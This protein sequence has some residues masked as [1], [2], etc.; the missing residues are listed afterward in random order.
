[1]PWIL[2]LMS[3]NAAYVA[4][5]RAANVFYIA[6]VVLHPLLGLAAVVWVVWK[7][8]RARQRT[9]LALLAPATLLGIYLFFAGAT[10]DHRVVLWSHVA[11]A[12]VGLCIL[13]PRWSIALAVLTLAVAGLRFGLP[14]D[15]IPNPEKVPMSKTEEGEGPKTPVW[16]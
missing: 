1:M 3:V 13:I 8:P 7:L 12:I 5:L 2:L 15:R 4:A 6:N 10:F 11:F 14:K 9:V 16:P